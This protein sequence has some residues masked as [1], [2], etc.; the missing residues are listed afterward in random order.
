MKCGISMLKIIK[1]IVT[2]LMTTY[3]TYLTVSLK[4]W[5]GALDTTLCVQVRLWLVT[6]RW[7][8]PGTPL[9]YK[10][11]TDRH[12]I[13][14]ID[15]IYWLSFHLT[16]T[17]VYLHDAGHSGIFFVTKGSFNE[18]IL[19]YT[20]VEVEIM[21]RCTRYNIMCSS[22]SVT[23]DRSVVLSGHSTFLIITSFMSFLLQRN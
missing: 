19:A 22:A 15:I 6:D 8:Y 17:V 10:N 20:N 16:S 4:S 23:C 21:A 1:L 9:S 7:F 14:E 5:R 18:E 13:T 12:D 11:K 2:D 3:R